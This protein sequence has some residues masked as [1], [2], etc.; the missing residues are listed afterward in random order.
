MTLN[1][2]L[3]WVLKPVVFL[4]CLV[5]GILL[6]YGTYVDQLGANP[7][8]E[9]IN[10]TGIW[11]L[12][13]LLLTL[14]LSPLKMLFSLGVL[15]RFR[16]MLGLYAFFYLCLHFF[17]YVVLEQYFDWTEIIND[18]IT[19]PHFSMGFIGFVLMIPLAL[20]SVDKII[21]WMG[22]MRWRKLH[23][24]VYLCTL[25]SVFHFL[26]LVKADLMEPIIY[27]AIFIFLMCFH[28]RKRR[29]RGRAYSS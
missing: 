10:L 5:P 26:M 27:G 15:L 4:I 25:F 7:I 3:S 9:I 29:H 20:T 24:L 13:F 2:Y 14:S 28:L 18:L 12:R 11:S 1:W 19:R 17:A 23:Q 16:R 22:K 8:E 6:A 21:E